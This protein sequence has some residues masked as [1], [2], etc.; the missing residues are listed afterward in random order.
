MP[1]DPDPPKPPE[2]GGGGKSATIKKET[3]LQRLCKWVKK[4]IG[5]KK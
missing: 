3:W 5:L 4:Q 1:V 2:G